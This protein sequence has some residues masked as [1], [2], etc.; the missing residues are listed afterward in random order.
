[1]PQGAWPPGAGPLTL[2][3]MYCSMGREGERGRQI[4]SFTVRSV[5]GGRLIVLLQHKQLAPA[6]R[7]LRD[8]RGTEEA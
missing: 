6:H 3:S 5:E 4:Q 7:L 8:Q 1:M 2:H